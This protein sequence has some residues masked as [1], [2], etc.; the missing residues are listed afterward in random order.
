MVTSGE[1]QF[2]SL[3]CCKTT[4]YSLRAGTPQAIEVSA[5]DPTVV[6]PLALSVPLTLKPQ[7]IES[8]P[9]TGRWKILWA[10]PPSDPELFLRHS[11]L[12]L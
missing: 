2:E 12:N 4:E 8:T 9:H 5:M 10:D 11:R 1:L 3:T 7:T 6:G